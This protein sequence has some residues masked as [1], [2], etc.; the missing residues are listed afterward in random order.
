MTRLWLM[1]ANEWPSLVA[2]KA[3]NTHFSL[4]DISFHQFTS[5]K[6]DRAYIQLCLLGIMVQIGYCV[7]EK[8]HGSR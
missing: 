8:D 4:I 1:L 5:N 7:I 3:P 6:P 2:T